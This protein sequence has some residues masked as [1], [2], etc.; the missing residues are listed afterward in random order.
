MSDYANPC[1]DYNTPYFA[2]N[3]FSK[4]DRGVYRRIGDM[5]PEILQGENVITALDEDGNPLLSSV[6]TPAM[7]LTWSSWGSNQSRSDIIIF[8]L[9]NQVHCLL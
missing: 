2:L 1:L 6:F 9:W 5:L 8:G 7:T 3:T 4:R